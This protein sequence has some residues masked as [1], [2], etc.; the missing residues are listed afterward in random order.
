MAAGRPISDRQRARKVY[1]FV[2]RLPDPVSTAVAAAESS[3]AVINLD[4]KESVRFASTGSVTLPP[5]DVTQAIDGASTLNNGDR[6]L[7]KN[8][9][10]SSE[11]GI[12]IVNTTASTWAR[13][14][15]AIPGSTLTCGA[16][17]YVED[18][19]AHGGEKWLLST[20]NVTL[21]G[22]QT[23][24]LFDAGNDWIVS[25][26]GG[27][28]K[29]ADAISIGADYPS[30]IANDIF[31]FVSGTRG[32]S[33]SEAEKS[34]FGGDVV[35][36]GSLSLAPGDGWVGPARITGS[37][38]HTGS[39]FHT[40]SSIIGYNSKA[41]GSFSLALGIAADSRRMGQFSQAGSGFS[42]FFDGGNT[43]GTTQY[44][45]FVWAGTA[46]NGAPEMLF[47]GYDDETGGTR[48]AVLP[49]E[50]NK[51]Y[52]VRATAAIHDS[53]NISNSAM[54]I[55]DAL[56]YKSGGTVTRTNI[57][58]TLSLPNA[59]TYDLDITASGS[60][61]TALIDAVSPTTFSL[62]GQLRGTVTIE[63]VEI[64]TT[65]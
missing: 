44:S 39:L 29:T 26:S 30:T 59:S 31:F 35:I 48:T 7:L 63:L 21:G 22:N 2:Q 53:S 33:G 23:W 5:G 32:K 58:T 34:V 62:T 51:T 10:T 28:M 8:Q 52:A 6:I 24:V 19:T 3:T 16:T 57:N 15:D 25:G 9:S 12:Y 37:L 18:G 64:R 42:N 41:T 47:R 13:T 4:W 46:G 17:T 11:N 56:F 54:F 36:S 61:I 38:Y 49:L 65:G 50:D 60:G 14:D 45:R 43:P 27:Q 20:T 1:G 40:G 55:R